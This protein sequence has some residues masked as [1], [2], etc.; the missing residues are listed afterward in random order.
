MT[1]DPAKLQAL[2]YEIRLTRSEASRTPNQLLD[3]IQRE[4]SD[5]IRAADIARVAPEEAQWR[6]D[7]DEEWKS[8]PAAPN[9]TS[10]P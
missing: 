3:Y 10:S 9:P 6:N 8:F 5:L 2:L 1:P 7:S 4:L